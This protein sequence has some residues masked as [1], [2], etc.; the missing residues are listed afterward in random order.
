MENTPNEIQPINQSTLALNTLSDDTLTIAQR[1]KA[2]IKD[3]TGVSPEDPSKFLMELAREAKE[4]DQELAY[5]CA[6]EV[7][8]NQTKVAEVYAK[9]EQQDQQAAVNIN[10]NTGNANSAPTFELDDM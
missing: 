5:K 3:V 4:S 6:T 2:I 9:A 8:K 10:M 1:H 7:L